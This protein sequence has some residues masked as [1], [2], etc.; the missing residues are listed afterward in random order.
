MILNVKEHLQTE[1]QHLTFDEEKHIYYWNGIKVPKSVS[2]KVEEHIPPFDE[3]YWLP[4]CAAKEGITEHELRHQ[5]L[6]TNI[7]ACELGTTVHKFLERY[8]GTQTPSLPQE[9]A[10]IHFLR[11]ILK[12]Y[13]IV[14]KEV[15]MYSIE[16]NYAG[17]AD[18]LLRHKITGD[19]VLADYKTNKDIFKTFRWMNKPFG[20]LENHPYN[21]YQLQLGYYQIMLDDI[22]LWITN[23]KIVYLKSDAT[24]RIFDTVDFAKEIRL[25]LANPN[26]EP[27]YA[28][29]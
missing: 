21:H 2:A 28:A 27:S 14:A 8:D 9:V 24:Y 15:R 18:L 7:T 25:Y 6:T 26:K 3:S 19:L 20:Y 1:F 23:R 4:I 5:W 22:G 13:E 17:T 29:Y 10:G 11:E 12:E 16:Y